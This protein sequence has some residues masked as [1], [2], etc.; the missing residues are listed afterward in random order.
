MRPAARAGRASRTV[1]QPQPPSSYTARLDPSDPFLARVVRALASRSARLL[2]AFHPEQLSPPGG[3]RRGTRDQV[4]FVDDRRGRR[5]RRRRRRTRRG[6]RRTLAADGRAIRALVLLAACVGAFLGFFSARLRLSV[7][8]TLPLAA[9]AAATA[10]A[11]LLPA[12]AVAFI[13]TA[14]TRFRGRRNP[15]W[16]S[17]VD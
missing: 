5:G 4:G 17:E 7:R 13:L 6:R 8:A 2:G 12:G 16:D 15:G 9:P 10:A 3:A 14:L 1:P 11:A